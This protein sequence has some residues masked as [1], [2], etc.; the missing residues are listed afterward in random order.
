MAYK[1]YDML[2]LQQKVNEIDN[3]CEK[4]YVDEKVNKVNSSLEEKASQVD[5]ITERNRIN[6]IV[7]NEGTSVN[8]LELQDIRTGENG[9]SYETA[10]DAIREQ[11]KEINSNT[12]G[13]TALF[14]S[15]EGLINFNFVNRKITIPSGY[16]IVDRKWYY[17]NGFSIDMPL[18]SLAGLCLLY[19][20]TENNV[21]YAKQYTQVTDI[22][23]SRNIV[24]IATWY[25]EDL[26]SISCQSPYKVNGIKSTQL[27]MTAKQA[28]YVSD[29][30]IKF[31]FINSTIEFENGGYVVVDKTWYYPSSLSVTMPEETGMCFLH[32][33]TTTKEFLTN[34][35]S[36]VSTLNSNDDI[37]LIATWINPKPNSISTASNYYTV[38]EDTGYSWATNEFVIPNNLYMIKDIDYG[39]N[40]L[41]FNTNKFGCKDNVKFEIITPGKDNVFKDNA[42]LKSKLAINK[43]KTLLTGICNDD[44]SNALFK[45]L[46]LYFADPATKT[47]KS[48]TILFIGDSITYAGLASNC[49]VWLKAFGFNP[50]FIGTRTEINEFGYGILDIPMVKSEGM[51]GWRITDVT[52][53]SV[54]T[55]G[56]SLS[57]G[58]SNKFLNPETG[59]FDF[60]YFMNS[61]SFTSVDFV[62]IG[63]GHNDLVGYPSAAQGYK[64]PTIEEILEYMPVEYLKIINSIKSFN[65]NVRIGLNP[66]IPC[67]S[68][69]KNSKYFKFTKQLL[70]SFQ[71]KYDNVDILSSYLSTGRLSGKAWDYNVTSIP[72]NQKNIS[73]NIH[74]NGCSTLNNGLWTASWIVARSN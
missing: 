21:F 27:G 46:T 47:N 31:D 3:K 17:P 1:N 10:G 44:Y 5:L 49:N 69:D 32:F 29:N 59:E 58:S 7:K 55:N 66:P 28:L 25:N 6:N 24:L 23:T 18:S 62:I 19:Y 37:V 67:N 48:P 53:T 15:K 68:D 11:F 2:S 74:D 73:G 35:Y 45:D 52:N 50:T 39:I 9:K 12:M 34:Q 8:D 40:A 20:D 57:K 16:V 51:S 42:V 70:T 54:G 26:K 33:N 63:L 72:T 41:N 64:V 60:T 71:N 4:D 38:L 30:G 36:N 65:P 61:N 13:K 56:E 43:Y 14:V 22:A